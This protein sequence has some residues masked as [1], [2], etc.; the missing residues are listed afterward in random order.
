MTD[1]LMQ[2]SSDV[3]PFTLDA[4]P[5]STSSPQAAPRK[6]EAGDRPCKACAAPLKFVR[7]ADGE[8]IVPLD[9]RA[10]V[11]VVFHNKEG[12]RLC[13]NMREFLQSVGIV[14][15]KRADGTLEAMD[16]IEGVYVSHF[17]TCPKATEFS[18]G[19]R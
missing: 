9:P 10:P 18:K 14:A 6:A 5:A 16:N 8:K 12:Q 17:A 15:F 11:F 7:Q 1:P 4:T 19:K 3:A 13:W 2:P